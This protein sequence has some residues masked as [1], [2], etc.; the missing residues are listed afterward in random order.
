M[1]LKI[2]YF[3][4]NSLNLNMQEKV[5]IKSSFKE[6]LQKIGCGI[7]DFIT[8]T[9]IEDKKIF[10]SAGKCKLCI[11]QDELDDIKI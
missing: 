3:S 6:Q 4:I 9:R 10:F 8:I 2:W 7:R 1:Q 11:P 5:Y